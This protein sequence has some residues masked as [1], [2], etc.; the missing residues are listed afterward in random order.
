M[1]YV[2]V[3]LQLDDYDRWRAVLDE[4]AEA[5][6]AH[7][8]TGIE[9]FRNPDDTSEVMA[10]FEWVSLEKA[11]TFAPPKKVQ[12]AMERSGVIGPPAIHFLD[13]VD[14]WEP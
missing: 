7:G 3:R 12:D 6:A 2:L 4:Q 11:R 5:R 14:S 8:C 13:K 1:P 10:L 9:I